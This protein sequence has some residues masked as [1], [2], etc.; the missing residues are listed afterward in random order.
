MTY[1]R[2]LFTH[3]GDIEVRWVKIGNGEQISVKGKRLAAITSYTGTKILSIV[4][5]INQ[6]LL[7]VGQLLEKGFK[8]IFEDKS[9][10]IKDPVSLEMFK[11]K[12]RS[13]S[14]LFYSLQDVFSKRKYGCCNGKRGLVII[15]IKDYL[16]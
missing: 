10:I 14:F 4:P 9:C 16:I 15:T 5:K 2:E 12:M 11:N 1:D 8:I 6:N 13:N 7:S 3:L